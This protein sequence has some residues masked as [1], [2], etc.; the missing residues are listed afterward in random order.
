MF[1]E[2]GI[3]YL[4]DQWLVGGGLVTCCGLSEDVG[5]LLAV[6]RPATLGVLPGEF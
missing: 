4:C 3:N 6:A 1:K 5:G 2:T